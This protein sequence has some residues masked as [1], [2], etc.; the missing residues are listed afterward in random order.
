MGVEVEAE[1]VG[2]LWLPL[3]REN[4]DVIVLAEFIEKDSFSVICDMIDMC[5]FEVLVIVILIGMK[6]HNKC[7]S[8]CFVG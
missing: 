7:R 2:L 8:Y 3:E 1:V 4:P 5:S 6:L